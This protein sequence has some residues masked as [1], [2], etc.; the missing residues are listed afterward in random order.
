MTGDLAIFLTGYVIGLASAGVA[1]GG[2]YAGFV[3]RAKAR[4]WR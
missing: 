3:L 2:A 4:G 1:F